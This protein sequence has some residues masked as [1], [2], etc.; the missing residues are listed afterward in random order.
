M[1]PNLS[2]RKSVAKT[3]KS[4]ND[5]SA[6]V[7]DKLPPKSFTK[8]SYHAKSESQG[9]ELPQDDREDTHLKLQNG[10]S[11]DLTKR[12]QTSSDDSSSSDSEVSF[13]IPRK[14]RKL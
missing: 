11:Q 14:N 12:K 10:F 9:T 1:G 8:L 13:K 6:K 3:L 4:D 5:K 2:K 7:N